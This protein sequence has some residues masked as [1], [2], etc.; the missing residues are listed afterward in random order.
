[1][2]KFDTTPILGYPIT[3]FKK[4]IV[5]DKSLFNEIEYS[6]PLKDGGVSISK[7]HYILNNKKF[8]DIKDVIIGVVEKYKTDI[9]GIK[10]NIQITNS[11]VTK[12]EP[13]CKH[14]LHY[15]PNVFI[16]LTHY[17]DCESGSLKFQFDRSVIS[18]DWSISY[19]IIDYNIFNSESWTFDVKTDSTVIFPGV[20]KHQSTTN[21]SNKKRLMLGA[22]FFFKGQYGTYEDLNKVVF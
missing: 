15:H 3:H 4:K 8:S 14:F 9:L 5:K 1:M 6:Y 2:I 18:R 16:S 22:N 21:N 13:G 10:N 19:D 17:I 11:W 20:I 12:N 7:D